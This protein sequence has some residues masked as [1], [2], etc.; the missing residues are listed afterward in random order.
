[1]K[2]IVIVDDSAANLRIYTK[3]SETIDPNVYVKAF[4]NP[5]QAVEWLKT[6][7]PDLV[8]TDYK[9]PGM[10]GAEFT[11]QIRELSS[12]AEVPV[13]I[14]TAYTDRDFR[15]EALEAGA[16]DFLLSPIDYAEFQPRVRNLLRLSSHQRLIQKRAKILE[17]DLQQS[18]LLRDQILRDSHD[19]LA[20][21]I[22]TVPAMV[23]AIDPQGRSIFVNAYQASLL[24]QSRSRQTDERDHL[25]LAT[26]QPVPSFEEEIR[27]QNGECRTFLSTKTPLRS[28]DG[29]T[30]GVLTTSLDI[31]DRKRAEGQLIFQAEHDYLTSLPNRYYLNRWLA[32]EID[33]NGDRACR[34]ALYYIDLDR[35]KFV[36]DGF[37]HHFGDLLLQAVSLRLTNAVRSGDIVARLG[38]DEFALLQRNVGDLADAIPFAA[39]INQ[40]L[41]APF[42]I[43]GRE[44]TTSASI[45][46]TLYPCDG[47]SA[48]ELLQNA[49][50]AMYR[51][52]ARGRNG[53]EIFSE[54]IRF[55]A[56]EAVRIRSLLQGALARQEFVLHYQPQIDLKTGSVVG[57]EALIRWSQDGRFL[58]PDQFLAIAEDSNLMRPIDEW[59]LREACMQAKHWLGTLAQ[60]LRVAVNLS[61]SAFR[62][63]SLGAWVMEVLRDVGLPPAL[64]DLELTEGVLLDQDQTTSR[65]VV[66][67]HTHGVRLSIDDFGTG[68]SSLARL[69]S[70]NVDTLKIDRSF[71]SHLD[72]PNNMAIVRA[73]TSLGRALN[74]EVLAEGVETASQLAQVREAGCDLVQGYFTGRPMDARELERL[75]GY[76]ESRDILRRDGLVGHGVEDGEDSCR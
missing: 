1:M 2:I 6:N 5:E 37:G 50:L 47:K 27:D 10:T 54:D 74:A 11:R 32:R 52:K 29:T 35:F 61:A 67:L 21:V 12:C 18:E 41:L 46:V 69:S 43:E 19:Q 76:G 64:L 7:D 71:V 36:N 51:V 17:R 23:S 70:L 62:D 20:Q 65:E 13:V 45:G 38:G 34:F 26:D 49:D 31:T 24:G 68:Y 22:D 42:T 72:K 15:I 59:V 73:V 56:R 8:I 66:A 39:R 44:V 53:T 4:H 9:M 63:P 48:Q 55:Q 30:T 25:V 40:L 75:L 14:V 57:A 33:T 16:T 60:P 28:A 3:L 58:K